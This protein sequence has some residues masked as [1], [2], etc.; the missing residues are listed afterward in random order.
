MRVRCYPEGREGIADEYEIPPG[1]L[2]MMGAPPGAVPQP[3]R[4]T[5]A[6]GEVAEIY[7][8][9][10]DL[11]TDGQ[12]NIC[13]EPVDDAARALPGWHPPDEQCAAPF[14]MFVLTAKVEI[15]WTAAEV[16]TFNPAAA[17]ASTP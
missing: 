10:W 5:R 9:E 17:S 6:I 14:R 7:A 13:V 2:G 4:V 3:H 8:E 11:N 15:E 16:A 12:Q 1:M